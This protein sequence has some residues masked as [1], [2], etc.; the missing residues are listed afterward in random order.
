MDGSKKFEK[1]SK[2]GRQVSWTQ[3]HWVRCT[4]L[5]SAMELEDNFEPSTRYSGDVEAPKPTV[6]ERTQ[7]RR[8][9]KEARE[10]QRELHELRRWTK[11]G[12]G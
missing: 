9:G 4:D 2:K 5:E 1:L 7:P 6:R 3:H 10:L 12:N 11:R 8:M